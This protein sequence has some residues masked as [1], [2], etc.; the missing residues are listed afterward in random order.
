MSQTTEEPGDEV[1]GHKHRVA[2]NDEPAAEGDDEVE[3]HGR[4]DG[5]VDGRTDSRVDKRVD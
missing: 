4:L 2:Q 1:E 5:R 3:A